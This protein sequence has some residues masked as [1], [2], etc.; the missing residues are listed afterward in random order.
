MSGLENVQAPILMVDDE[1]QFLL[2]AS[3]ALAT[4]GVNN[5]T[6]CADSREV[7]ALLEEQHFAV[8]IL[9]LI[10]PHFSGRNCWK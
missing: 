5:V 10:M 3:T 9:D 7:M 2:S 8:I 1:E 6:E 4:R